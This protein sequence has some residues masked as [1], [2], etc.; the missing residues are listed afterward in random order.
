MKAMRFF[1]K[2]SYWQFVL[3]T[4]IPWA[5]ILIIIAIGLYEMPADPMP[6]FL[7]LVFKSAAA[8]I[9]LKAFLE[10]GW[11]WSVVT[12]LHEKF[13]DLTGAKVHQMK[14][15]IL[16]LFCTYMPFAIALY[17]NLIFYALRFTVPGIAIVGVLLVAGLICWLSLRSFLIKTLNE[18][19][20]KY[21]NET[22]D[23]FT[24]S[25]LN[26]VSSWQVQE[27]LHAIFKN[28]PDH[29]VK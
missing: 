5:I 29:K 2:L 21:Y 11:W 16:L 23:G 7:F 8:G 25:A 13:P 17:F 20:R 4:G 24:F 10:C 1:V 3:I 14:R 12:S 6:Y 28:I 19:A 9:V 15:L 26:P 18:I 22:I 27:I